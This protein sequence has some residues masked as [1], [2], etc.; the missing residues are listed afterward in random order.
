[1]PISITAAEARDFLRRHG[2]PASDLEPLSGGEWSAAFAFRE[3]QRAYVVRFHERRDDLEKDLYA[4]RWVSSRLRTPRVVEIGDLPEGAYG[5]SER[6]RGTPLD[7]LD[8][9][10][11]RR[12][13]PSLLAAMDAMRDADLSGTRGFWGWHGDGNAE[14]LSWHDTLLGR[15]PERDVM[16]E[17]RSIV[18]A[19]PLGTDAYDAALTAIGELLP[20]CPEARA[21]VHEDL[22]NYNVLVDDAGVVL[23]DWGASWYG[24]WVYDIALLAFWWPH[25][26]RWRAIDV[27]AELRRHHAGIGLV[28]PHFAERLRC[29]MLHLGLEHMPYQIGR[30]RLED[31]RW[32]AR[33]TM[34]LAR[35]PL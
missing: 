25:Y 18:A 33:R 28:V 29:C 24:D 14:A 35:M 3:D 32:T 8:E 13:L 20:S 27:V 15:L 17:W 10:G 30:G 22:L 19:S 21:L 4:Q 1:M 23:L 7:D 31:A 5:I 9:V 26:E 2:H 34:E 6:V 12:A 16:A 11:M